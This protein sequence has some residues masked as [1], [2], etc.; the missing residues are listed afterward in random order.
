MELIPAAFR[1]LRVIA[2][3]LLV[4]TLAACAD[5]ALLTPLN[6]SGSGQ[7]IT[8]TSNLPYG[9]ETRQRLDVYRPANARKA[10]VMLFWYGGSWQ[11]GAKD[12]YGFVGS[13]LA[14][15][16][17]VA[18]LP[19]YRLAPDHPFPAFVEDAAS[20]VRWARDHATEFGG[21]AAR[22][23]V[24]GHSAG[25]HN[26]LVLALDPRY[27]QAVGME[28]K[29]I[30]GVVSLAGPTGLEHLR[31]PD[32]KGVFPLNVPD[33]AFSPIALAARNASEAPP[34]L[35]MTGLDDDV[36]YPGSVAQLADAIR[37]GGGNVTIKA[38]PDIGHLGL[39]LDLFDLV[40]LHSKVAADMARFA[41]L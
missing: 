7:K 26:A 3:A 23:Y 39:L 33:E 8:V 30:A 1:H 2:I 6:W 20:A 38:Y 5:E 24:S 17:F 19:D 29:G 12:Y 9:A 35:L 21:D 18:V 15:Q 28:P 37:A 4:G 16:G 36:I 11:H 34:F 10:P 13:A 27:L 14:H 25:G 32:L 40:E 31:G 22:I 41:G